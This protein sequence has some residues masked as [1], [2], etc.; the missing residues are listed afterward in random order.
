[1]DRGKDEDA[2]SGRSHH[3]FASANFSHAPSIRSRGSVSSIDR[4]SAHSDNRHRTHRRMKSDSSARMKYL[5]GVTTAHS[6]TDPPT[7]DNEWRLNA[8]TGS[9]RSQRS[10]IS[11][12]SDNY[13]PPSDEDHPLGPESKPILLDDM[14]L[15]A[16]P[17][18]KNVK[19][20]LCTNLFI[21]PVIAKCGHTFCKSCLLQRPPAKCPSH[22]TTLS[23]HPQSIIPNITVI[24]QISEL[25]I[26]CRYGVKRGD[27]NLCKPMIDEEGCKAII[28]LGDR[29]EHEK[30]CEFQ[31]VRCPNSVKCGPLIKRDLDNH[32]TICD[33]YKCPHERQGCNFCGTKPDMEAHITT[34]KFESVKGL[35]LASDTRIETLSQGLENKD[36]EI[37]FLKSMLAKLSERV[38]TI[39][40]VTRDRLDSLE[41]RISQIVE[42]QG[43]VDNSVARTLEEVDRIRGVLEIEPT[44]ALESSLHNFKCKGTFLGHQGPVWALAVH[45]D[46]LFSGSSDETI[47]VWETRSSAHFKCRQTLND[48]AG[49]VHSLATHNQR[50]YSGSSDRTIK[51]WDIGTC[52]L[53]TTLFGHDDPVCTLT[54]ANGML[55]SGSLKVVK[56]WDVY[57]HELMGELNGLNHWV[58]AL[59]GTHEYLFAGSYQT[60]SV[61]TSDRAE[62]QKAFQNGE[63]P[64]VRHTLGTS[65]GSVYSLCISQQFVMCGTFANLVHIWAL[66][67][68]EEVIT[69]EGHTGTVYALAVL[70]EGSST[71]LFSASYDRSIRVW[72]MNNFDCLQELVRHENSCNAVVIHREWLFS[73]AADSTIKVWSR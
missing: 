47:K 7:Y 9:V 54:V 18:P 44:P 5:D 21:E 2:V 55:F 11:T 34:C 62:M 29:L 22:G 72:D 36:Q 52:Q 45:N 58:R 39:E 57:T 32:L 31:P 20:P 48:H 1:M 68:F 60:I 13:G 24:E 28:P 42:D 12:G 15:F 14:T 25:S 16:S 69:L 65:G 8:G 50:L 63:M 70:E 23:L 53:V 27:D 46:L 26:H 10:F 59:Q 35:L 38:S 51:V 4:L 64:L 43:I 67:T 61:W 30:D 73:G 19:C 17:V 3:S 56:I 40:S 33:Q 6:P 49:I 66:H 41:I 71:L 37:E